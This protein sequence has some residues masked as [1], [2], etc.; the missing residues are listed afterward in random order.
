[1]RRM[2]LRRRMPRSGCRPLAFLQHNMRAESLSLGFF[3]GMF[4]PVR[5]E[6]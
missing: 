4:R 1:M 2:L 3:Q 5:T 6:Q